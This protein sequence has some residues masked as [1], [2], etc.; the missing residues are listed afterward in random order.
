M[1]C[2]YF[3][4]DFKIVYL[5]ASIAIAWLMKNVNVLEYPDSKIC[6]LR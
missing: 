3:K 1:K 2:G 4:G 6:I 5:C